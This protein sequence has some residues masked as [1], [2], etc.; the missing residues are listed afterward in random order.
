M[1]DSA[2]IEIFSHQS[3]NNIRRLTLSK[4]VQEWCSLYYIPR[5][6]FLFNKDTTWLT[7]NADYPTEGDSEIYGGS[8]L[9]GAGLLGGTLDRSWSL[10]ESAGGHQ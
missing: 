6:L 5:D 9:Q 2:T 10:P 1:V 4:F 8:A 3:W 7:V